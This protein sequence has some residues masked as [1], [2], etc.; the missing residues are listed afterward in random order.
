MLHFLPPTYIIF[1]LISICPEN[2]NI[3]QNYKK[4]WTQPNFSWNKFY[5]KFSCRFKFSGNTYITFLTMRW[6]SYCC[7]INFI[8]NWKKYNS[9]CSYIV[10]ISSKFSRARTLY[11]R[12]I[13]QKIINWMW[14]I[15]SFFLRVK[16]NARFSRRFKI[17]RNSLH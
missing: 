8:T 4:Q 2:Y 5:V 10:I 9:I 13:Y 6:T 7:G 14:K 1:C 17:R 12:P 16:F 15:S 3:I 11:R